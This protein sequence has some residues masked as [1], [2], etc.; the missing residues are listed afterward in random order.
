MI[1]TTRTDSSHV[2]PSRVSLLALLALPLCAASAG[3]LGDTSASEEGPGIVDDGS[4][5]SA[6][7]LTITLETYSK[8][9]LVADK[10]GGA[11]M[12]AYSTQAKEWETFTLTDQNGGAL[13]SGDVV[14]LKSGGG[15]WASADKGGGGT[16]TFTAPWEKA[17][18]Q[19]RIVKLSGAGAIASGDK[20]ALKTVVTG[21]FVSAINA[22]GGTVVAS[23]PEAREWETLTLRISGS[24]GGGSTGGT[25]TSGTE[26]APYFPS[27]TFDNPSVYPYANLVDLRN[28]TGITGVTLAF[29]LAGNG[30]KTD[31]DVL[32]HVDDIKAFVAKGGHVKAS[33][34]GAS[35]TYIEARCSDPSSL[36]NAIGAFVDASGIKDLDFDIEQDAAY[37]LS[38]LRGKALKILQDQKGIK[39]AFTLPTEPTGLV[40][41]GLKV[42]R[43]ALNAG[44]RISHVNLMTMDYGQFQGKPLGPVAI[45]S[46]NAAK[47]QLKG[48]IPG[49]TDAQAYAMLGATP[50]IG[51]ND[52]DE[53]FSL[54]DAA[55]LAQFARDNK[56]GLIAFWSIDRD[57]ACSEGKDSCSTV[58][59]GSFDFHNILK[60]SQQ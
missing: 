33:F 40:E 38:D 19:F 3:C 16:I 41:G 58:N 57:R 37:N 27:W 12:M 55:Q 25:T 5:L 13:T 52:T 6:T 51:R 30:C 21:Q 60:T 45:Q 28:K 17:W 22:G 47:G 50:M 14:T 32:S 7:R 4:A 2:R 43:G 46:V 56:L 36:A 39:V 42:V 24:S 44:V 54:A 18:E 11:A 8:N 1:T 59:K 29:V 48:L 35:G 20:I 9:F 10:G 23:A 53:M 49:L 26:Y 31:G 15:Q 34:G